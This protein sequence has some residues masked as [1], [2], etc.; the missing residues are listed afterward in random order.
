MRQHQSEYKFFDRKPKISNATRAVQH[1]LNQTPKVI[2]SQY[3]WDKRGIQLFEVICGLPD[4]YLAR[5]EISILWKN[6][7]LLERALGPNAT[8]IEYGGRCMSEKTRVLLESIHPQL[9]VPVDHDAEFVQEFA[10]LIFNRYIRLS[11]F[12]VRA[13]YFS[14]FELPK[15]VLSSNHMV[16][17]FGN[18]LSQLSR[19]KA[20]VILKEIFKTVG[21]GGLLLIGLDLRKEETV[22]NRGYNE[23]RGVTAKYNLNVLTHLNRLIDTNFE[24]NNFQHQAFYNV[25]EGRSEMSLVSL[26]DQ[27]VKVGRKQY[28]IQKDEAILTECHYRYSRAEVD[29]LIRDTSWNELYAWTDPQD[30]YVVLLLQRSDSNVITLDQ[31]V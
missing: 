4:Y 11:V 26:R 2:P 18:S 12:P 16:Y 5:V 10:R 21:D 28:K 19:R 1:G 7:T 20:H 31:D 22:I 14:S 8:L 9:Y 30:Y 3:L 29:A 25:E 24:T 23:L 17:L 13:N 27:Q 6:R 15:P